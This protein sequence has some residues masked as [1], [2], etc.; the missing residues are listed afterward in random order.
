MYIRLAHNKIT[1]EFEIYS[2]R[3]IVKLCNAAGTMYGVNLKKQFD[4]YI[5][6][7]RQW[8]KR[9]Q[10]KYI[11][12][13]P[14]QVERV[15]LANAVF[16]PHRPVQETDWLRYLRAIH[17]DY[18]SVKFTEEYTTVRPKYRLL[19]QEERR[20]YEILQ[21]KYRSM[22]DCEAYIRCQNNTLA[23]L[24]GSEYKKIKQE[25]A[26]EERKLAE[27]ADLAILAKTNWLVQCRKIIDTARV[28]C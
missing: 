19:F 18:I 21:G 20:L 9:R 14:Y 12:D 16:I 11:R 3:Q 28:I 27:I 15:Y 8:F 1:A 13:I 2:F 7:E 25:I 22:R 24:E 6:V 17:K 10:S 5:T 4:K 23:V 26:A